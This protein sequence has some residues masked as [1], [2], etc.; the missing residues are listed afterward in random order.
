MN[1]VDDIVNRIMDSEKWPNLELPEN[2]ELL[3]ELAD[4]SFS[5]GTFS[6]MLSAVL[7]YHQLYRSDVFAFIGGLSFFNSAISASCNHSFL[8]PGEQNVRCLFE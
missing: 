2:L 6:G 4:E 5:S 3:N 1:C 8:N 7:M